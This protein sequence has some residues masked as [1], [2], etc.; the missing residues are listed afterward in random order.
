MLKINYHQ[1]NQNI[2]LAGLQKDK[3]TITIKNTITPI[4]NNKVLSFKEALALKA[5]ALT[6]I[7]FTGNSKAESLQDK[8]NKIIEKDQSRKI[9]V[10]KEVKPNFIKEVATKITDQPN[11]P[12][13]IG[14]TGGSTSG[15]STITN[16]IAGKI[17]ENFKSSDANTLKPITIINGDMY[18]KD[19]S[20]EFKTVDNDIIKYLKDI[21]DL[22]SP[23]NVNIEDMNKDLISLKDGNEVN[24]PQY[25]YNS[26]TSSPNAINKKPAHC[27]IAESIFALNPKIKDIFDVKIFIDTP[28]E[29]I[30]K[31]WNNRNKDRIQNQEDKSAIFDKIEARRA[32]YI[33]P[34][35]D[36][37]DIVINGHSHLEDIESITKDICSAIQESFEEGYKVKEPV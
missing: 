8:L 12:I 3:N 31:R 14:I 9:S 13:L 19:T 35:K 20:E 25:D 18:Y 28:Q 17:N 1:Q 5:I 22:N 10:I 37:A 30:Q 11:K 21:N 15:K 33:Q 2:K 27:V 36:Y 4:A 34:T 26:C 23:E 6:N 29:E 16:I 7:N 32:Q 24:I